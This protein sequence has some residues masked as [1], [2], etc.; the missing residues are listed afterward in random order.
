MTQLLT[1]R[2]ASERLSIKVP[3]VRKWIREGRIASIKIGKVVRISTE[4]VEALIQESYR[5]A[6]NWRI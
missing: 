4:D 2:E 6:Q 5:L 1:L 3:T